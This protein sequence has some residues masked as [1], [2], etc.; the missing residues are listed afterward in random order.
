MAMCGA[1]SCLGWAG[2]STG[3][4]QANEA[5]RGTSSSVSAT[6][7][8]RHEIPS[9]KYKRLV[10][11]DEF[12]GTSLDRTK[13]WQRRLGP[14]KGGIN[15]KE[16]ISLD[17]NGNLVIT[18]K[19]VGDEYHTAMMR[20]EGKFETRY[21]YFECRARL[22]RRAIGSWCAFWLQSNS[23]YDRNPNTGV[24]IDVFE[25]GP[26]YPS[27]VNHALIGFKGHPSENNRLA[28]GKF[29][30]FGVEW[31]SEG[32]VFYVDGEPTWRPTQSISHAKQFI[33][34]SVEV[35]TMNPVGGDRIDP[36]TY[37]DEM[38]VDYVRVYQ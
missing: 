27:K 12:D 25:Y 1:I 36:E 11:S 19:K 22:L 31:S 7:I 29:H 20:T 33:I 35:G 32:Y 26:R 28:D 2:R 24:E 16:A 13:W 6:E 34:L 9:R 37:P 30:T 8:P 10:W 4:L 5:E 3:L 17:G 38:L 14:R 15:V 18:V 23:S 21:G